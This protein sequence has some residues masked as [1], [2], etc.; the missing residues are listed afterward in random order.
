MH[1]RYDIKFH[2]GRP[3]YPFQQLLGCLP[4]ASSNFLPR[5]YANLMTNE[6]SPLKR[7]YPDVMVRCPAPHTPACATMHTAIR[8]RACVLSAPH[9]PNAHAPPVAAAHPSLQTIRIDMNGK[10]NPWEGVAL[11]PFIDER[12]MLAGIAEHA[13]NSTLSG[14]CPLPSSSWPLAPARMLTSRRG[15]GLLLVQRTS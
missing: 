1:S 3:F 15:V 14:V 6:A 11:I 2:M 10:R 5:S 13:P 8:A 4:A 9:P 12:D 7:Y